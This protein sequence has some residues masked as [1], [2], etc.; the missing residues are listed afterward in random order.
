MDL[1]ALLLSGAGKWIGL[2][3]GFLAAILGYGWM[4]FSAGRESAR[5]DRQGERLEAVE[6]AHRIE[7]EVASTDRS[8]AREELSKWAR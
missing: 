4:R 7:D 5:A 3:V 1:L 2:A 8:T 6:A